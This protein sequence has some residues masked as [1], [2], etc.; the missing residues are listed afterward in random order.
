MILFRTFPIALTSDIEKAFLQISVN[1]EERDFL[2]FLWFDDVFSD[3]PKIVRN[4]FARLIFGVNSSPFLLTGTMRKHISTYKDIDPDFVRKVTESFHVDDFTGGEFTFENAYELY[5]KLK[6]RFN[7]ANFNLRKWRTNHPKLRNLIESFE[8]EKTTKIER[9]PTKHLGIL[10]DDEN[11]ELLFQLKDTVQ[12]ALTESPTKRNVLKVIASFYD[13]LGIVQP[14]IVSLKVLFQEICKS[15]CSWDDVIPDDLRHKWTEM[16]KELQHIDTIRVKRPLTAT[17]QTDPICEYELHGFSDASQQAYGACVYLRTVTKS[18]KV[19]VS[20]ITS[21]TRVAPLKPTTIPRLELLGNTILA[22]LTTNVATILKREIPIDRI[23]YWTDS[24][25]TLAWI[26]SFKKEYKTFVENRLR[27]IRELT[28]A[29]DWRFVPTNCNPADMITRYISAPKII[30][31]SLWL[32]GPE[33]LCR[34]DTDWP[35]PPE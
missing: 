2:R 11:D 3:N 21:K 26:K 25:I 22:E 35:I 23:V 30:N 20:L 32:N 13:P 15:K 14:I 33:Y 17:D 7:D 29:T 31:D 9:E 27:K 16:I 10:W 12:D 6:L 28:N 34:N 8:N 24:Q 5:K 19:H 18:N 4:R 1:P